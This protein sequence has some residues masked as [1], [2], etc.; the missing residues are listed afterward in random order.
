LSA[1]IISIPHPLLVGGQE[2]DPVCSSDSFI[3]INGNLEIKF[4]VDTIAC[5][6]VILWE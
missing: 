4:Q 2:G 3:P 6:S 1:F 5:S